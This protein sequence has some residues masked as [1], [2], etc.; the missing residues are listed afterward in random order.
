MYRAPEVTLGKQYD[1]S[2]DMWSLGCVV[3]ELIT[4]RPLFPAVDENHLIELYTETL[5][6][7]PDTILL[8]SPKRK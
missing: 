5:G 7:V 4:G 1:F 8:D 3:F 2:V 6:V